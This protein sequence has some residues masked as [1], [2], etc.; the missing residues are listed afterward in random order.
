MAYRSPLEIRVGLVA[1]PDTPPFS[2]RHHPVSCI[3]PRA[4]PTN[5]L[6]YLEA[7][8]IERGTTLNLFLPPDPHA[9]GR[10]EIWKKSIK[11][12]GRNS[13]FEIEFAHHRGRQSFHDRF[14]IARHADRSLAGVFG[15][16]LTGLSATDFVLIGELEKP[17]LDKLSESLH[18]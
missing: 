16:S 12:F 5:F 13:G 17:A 8:R 6:R 10:A 1:N 18:L 2:N 11:E 9:P 14:Y 4:D 3:A 7:L 15:P